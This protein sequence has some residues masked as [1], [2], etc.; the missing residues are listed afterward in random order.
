MRL[1]GGIFMWVALYAA[2]G[3]W[4]ITLRDKSNKVKLDT[5]PD[6]IYC[7]QTCEKGT[8]HDGSYIYIY[9]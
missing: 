2:L 7:Q 1:L 6:I 3:I 4:H 5:T 8:K 9:R